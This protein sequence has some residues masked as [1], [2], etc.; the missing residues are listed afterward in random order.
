[1][2]LI[3][4]N[5]HWN[6]K[7]KSLITC[8]SGLCTSDK[9]K[10]K[11]KMK[12]FICFNS[13]GNEIVFLS[14][15]NL[16]DCV[17]F[18]TSI[19]IACAII[20]DVHCTIFASIRSIMT[21]SIKIRKSFLMVKI[22][23]YC[24]VWWKKRWETSFSAYVPLS[25]TVVVIIFKNILILLSKWMYFEN[26]MFNVRFIICVS[27]TNKKKTQVRWVVVIRRLAQG[28]TKGNNALPN[29]SSCCIFD[30]NK[31]SMKSPNQ[32]AWE[33]YNEDECA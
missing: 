10:M 21:M 9:K 15:L 26:I 14:S 16:Y 12:A 22:S 17:F 6:L 33:K 1:V 8:D 20:I 19:I 27:S 30:S 31:M 18:W 4:I 32:E 3:V 28:W 29:W 7:N 13:K 23:I 24:W 2:L 5:K 11:M 25:K